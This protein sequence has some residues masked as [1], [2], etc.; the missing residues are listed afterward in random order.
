MN[1][2]AL[3][4]SAQDPDRV[5]HGR[6]LDENGLEPALEG[7]VLLDVLAELV[8]GGRPDQAEFSTSEHRLQHVRSVHRTFGSTGSHDGVHLVDERDDPALGSLDLSQDGLEALLE[9]AP[10]LR[11]GNERAHVETDNPF[12]LQALGHVAV[13]DALCKPFDD[14]RLADAGF[15]D[16]HRIVLGTARQHLDRAADLLVAANHRVKPALLSEF[17]QVASVLLER[18]EGI[19]GV[20]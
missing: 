4:E 19:F 12:V 17:G 3:L 2:V 9:L 16:E 13:N 1:L 6:L 18:G 20:L 11:A 14:G 15:S 8:E 7:R 5:L 10:I